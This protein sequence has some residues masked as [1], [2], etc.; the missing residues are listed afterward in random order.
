[1]T[2]QLSKPTAIA[3]TV[4]SAGTQHSLDPGAEAYLVQHGI[5]TYVVAP[6]TQ[7]S[8]LVR[9]KLDT[10]QA[11]TGFLDP[12]GADYLGWDD[13]RFPAQGINPAGAETA[14]TVDTA[15]YGGTLLFP[16]NATAVVAGVAQMPHAWQ[17]GTSV[18]PHIHWAKTTSASGGVVWQFRYAVASFGQA[19]GAYTEW[20]DAGETA[21]DNNTA[22]QHAIAS[23][24]EINLSTHK[25]SCIILWQIRRKHDHASDTYAAD[26]RLFEF[27]IHYRIGKFG[28]LT[29]IPV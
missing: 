18:N 5:A 28:T 12:A 22:H 3:G 27:D 20:E 7:V 11:I 16:T 6:Q 24:S 1:M 21:P 17:R 15:T 8:D 29:E 9:Y 23:W 4:Q 26:A 10:A 2:I 13:L 19:F 25:E 14:P